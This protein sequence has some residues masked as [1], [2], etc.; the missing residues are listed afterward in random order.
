[1]RSPASS[2]SAHCSAAL[3]AHD[4]SLLNAG[5]T[6]VLGEAVSAKHLEC[7]PVDNPVRLVSE[8]R[9]VGPVGAWLETS[10]GAAKRYR[11]EFRTGCGYLQPELVLAMV[12]PEASEV[13]LRSVG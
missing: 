3:L 12:L 4:D 11:V 6:V 5:A 7:I 8:D 13:W 9:G 10:A 2:A 1:M